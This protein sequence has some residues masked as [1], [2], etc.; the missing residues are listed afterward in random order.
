MF[1]TL[2]FA[3][4]VALSATPTWAADEDYQDIVVEGMKDPFRISPKQLR[5]AVAAYTEG[6]PKLAPAAPLR[7]AVFRYRIDPALQDVRFRLLAD[8]GDAIPIPID[9]AGRFVLP[10]LDYSTKLYALQANRKAGAVR[11]RPLILSPDSNEDDRRLGDLRLECAVGWAM[12][13]DTVSVFVRGMIGAAGGLCS[14]SRIGAYQK[15][16]SP[17]A[18]GSIIAAK[19]AKPVEITKDGMAFRMPGYD[20][21]LPNE[22]RVRLIY[23]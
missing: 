2:S 5:E 22:A 21:S 9:N 1:R 8:N 14:S 7:F 4:A 19:L 18:S 6:Q 16:E 15:T 23:K 13:R 12:L 20:K 3:L 10:P 11:V 17:L